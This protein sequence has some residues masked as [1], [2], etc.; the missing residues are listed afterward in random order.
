MLLVS[1]EAAPAIN[2]CVSAP[3]YRFYSVGLLGA[4]AA[5]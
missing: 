2:H 4:K 3:A 1:R 5:V